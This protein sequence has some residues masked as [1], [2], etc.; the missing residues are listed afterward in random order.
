MSDNLSVTGPEDR[1]GNAS[2]SD[3]CNPKVPVI[4]YYADISTPKGWI[5]RFEQNAEAILKC[6]GSDGFRMARL[7]EHSSAAA[8][9]LQAQKWLDQD[10]LS[11]VV[12]RLDERSHL[13]ISNFGYWNQLIK[14]SVIYVG[15]LVGV[16]GGLKLILKNTPMCVEILKFELGA[17][18]MVG[19]LAL[20]W[21]GVVFER[22]LLGP[23]FVPDGI[24]I[25]GRCIKN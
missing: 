18:I 10:C 15:S 6:E 12:T 16:L 20:F 8:Q 14:S 4:S 11:L 2:L 23:A 13:M 7:I 24:I 19:S 25:P 5:D 9:S 1:K 22:F 3:L 17:Y 21:A